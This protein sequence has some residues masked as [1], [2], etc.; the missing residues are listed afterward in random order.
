M[1]HY[2]AYFNPFKKKIITFF[3]RFVFAQNK[4]N[5]QKT[6]KTKN[7]FIIYFSFQVVHFCFQNFAISF[8]SFGLP[9]VSLIDSICIPILYFLSDVNHNW[10][11]KIAKK[12]H[13]L[14]TNFFCLIKWC[15]ITDF[16]RIFRL[17]YQRFTPNY[18]YFAL[19]SSFWRFI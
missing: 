19:I 7:T 14:L 13:I 9:F 4:K 3:G 11:A 8:W 12:F 15:I 10:I 5:K 17:Y 1:K 2:I 16:T 18:S 6:N